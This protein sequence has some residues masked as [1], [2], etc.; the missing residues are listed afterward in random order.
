MASL[1]LALPA[2]GS[3]L[4]LAGTNLILVV[5]VAVIAVIVIERIVGLG[6]AM[7]AETSGMAPGRPA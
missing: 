7:A 4:E 1:E 3:A 6:R 2:A 5:T